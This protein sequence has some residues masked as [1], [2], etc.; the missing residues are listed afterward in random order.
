[1]GF[2]DGLNLYQFV[3]DNPIIA[4][5][6]SGQSSD[7]RNPP[8]SSTPRTQSVVRNSA[9]QSTN[10]R[11][12]GQFTLQWTFTVNGGAECSEVLVQEISITGV[13]TAGDPLAPGQMAGVVGFRQH[14]FEIVGFALKGQPSPLVGGGFERADTNDSIHDYWSFPGTQF[15]TVGTVVETGHVR[16]YR[17][18]SAVFDMLQ[19][20]NDPHA[21]DAI[22]WGDWTHVA[23]PAGIGGGSGGWMS[24]RDAS[25]IRTATLVGDEGK[26]E[27]KTAIWSFDG[28]TDSILI[29]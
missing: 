15:P 2:V 13:V 18:T 25:L 14:Y 11:L 7:H 22:S 5:D 28:Q 27:V 26:A 1:M 16:A 23:A 6:S 10:L 20:N 3:C 19:T 4:R 29:I 9:G 17:L 21:S 8:T 12:G 24:Y